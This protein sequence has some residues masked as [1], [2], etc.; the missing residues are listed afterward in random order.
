MQASGGYANLSRMKKSDQPAWIDE[1][2]LSR[3]DVKVEQAFSKLRSDAAFEDADQ[4]A[5]C[6]SERERQG[7]DEALCDEHLGQALGMNSTW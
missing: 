2:A 4:C 5:S 3:G 1:R 6:R 7:D